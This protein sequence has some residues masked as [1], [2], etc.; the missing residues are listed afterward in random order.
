MDDPDPSLSTGLAR[1][2]LLGCGL[3]FTALGALGAFLPVLPT[4]PFLLVAVAC[5]ARSSPRF[6]QRLLENRIFGPYLAQWQKDHTVPR[7]AK[8]KA[9]GLILLTFSLSIW[10]VEAAWLRWTLV[11]IGLALVVFL[12]SLRTTE[13]G[14]DTAGPA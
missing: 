13:N 2:L 10:L 11:G 3:T 4:T 9:Y 5:F 1:Y 7:E 12:M 8:R 14:R 6:H